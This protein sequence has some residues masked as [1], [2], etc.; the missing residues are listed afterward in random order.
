MCNKGQSQH[1]DV[2]VGRIAESVLWPWP[3][4]KV[5]SR[6][7]TRLGPRYGA[8]VIMGPN[9]ER[10]A[11]KRGNS[12]VPLLVLESKNASY[13]LFA[14]LYYCDYTGLHIDLGW[15]IP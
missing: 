4:G 9:R 14:K 7:E 8:Y 1:G 13:P 15:Q 6:R 11:E 10:P 2:L 3:F 5:G 12:F